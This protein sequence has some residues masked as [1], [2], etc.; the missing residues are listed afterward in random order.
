[1]ETKLKPR[2]SPQKPPKPEMKSS[3]VIFGDLSNSGSKDL[4]LKYVILMKYQ[5]NTVASPKKIFTIAISFSYA[6]YNT[7][8]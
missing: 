1:M 5:P 4:G 6:L 8:P 7:S 2:Q 3:Q